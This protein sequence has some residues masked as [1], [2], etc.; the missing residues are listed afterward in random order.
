MIFVTG[1]LHADYDWSKLNTKNFPEQKSLSRNDYVIVCGDFGAVWDSSKS[2][3]YVQEWHE[4]KTYTTLFVNGN[5]EN[6]DLLAQY[7]VEEWHGG[8]VQ[9]ITPHIIHLMRGQVYEINGYTFFTMGGAQSHDM[10]HRKEHVSWWKEELPSNEEYEE[11]FINLERVNN[12]VD[13]IITHCAPDDVQDLLSGYLYE[14]NKLTNF[15]EV[16]RQ[17]VEFKEWY[18]GHYHIDKD[19]GRYHCLYRQAPLKIGD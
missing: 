17:T 9:F 11:A 5:H 3:K 1:D 14:H 6:F 18:F 10:W 19:Y 15:L 16:V 2:D 8:K 4:N 12:K 13:Y 7:K